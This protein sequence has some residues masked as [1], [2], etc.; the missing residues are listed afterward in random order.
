VSTT[1]QDSQAPLVSPATVA[2]WRRR[3]E[4]C[5]EVLPPPEDGEQPANGF[6]VSG[7]A[8]AISS[9]GEGK[10]ANGF[11]LSVDPGAISSGGEG[12]RA[13]GFQAK[14]HVAT[15]GSTDSVAHSFAESQQAALNAMIGFAHLEAPAQPL[16]AVKPGAALAQHLA[17]PQGRAAIAA[18]TQPSLVIG[19]PPVT[20]QPGLPVRSVPVLPGR[21]PATGTQARRERSAIWDHSFAKIRWLPLTVILVIQAALSLRLVWSNSAFTDEALY[22]WSGRVEWAH[23]LHGGFI[24]NFPTYFSGAPVIYPPV[25][26]MAAALGGLTGARILSLCFM[27]NA[28]VLLHGVTRRIFDRRSAN[29][30]AAVFAGLGATQ[31][32]G[33]FATYDAMAL[34][35]L[36]LAT[37]LCV[38]AS[39]SHLAVQVLLLFGAG[40][41][42]ALAD[43]AKY[44]AALF[45]PVV[46]AVAG[47]V[48]WRT[49]GRKHGIVTVLVLL[50]VLGLVLFLGIREGGQPYWRGITSSTL[51]RTHGVSSPLGILADS[52]G[53]VFL[54]VVL[55]LIGAG[56]AMV[57]QTQ[58]PAKLC[59]LVLAGAVAL[60]PANQARIHVFTSLFKHVGFGAWFAAAVAGYALASLADAV[61]AVKKHKALTVSTCAAAVGILVGALLAQTH[62]ASWPNT[63]SLVAQLRTI[64]PDHRGNVLSS[65]NGNVIEYYLEDELDGMPFYGT[66]FFHYQDPSTGQSLT[67][68]PAYADAIRHRYFSV[69]VLSFSDTQATDEAIERDISTYGGYTLV[70]TLPY[71]VSGSASVF[72]IWVREDSG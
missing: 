5:S 60:A 16:P 40:G 50:W 38:R 8:D 18:P 71:R 17:P 3:Q 41:A 54:A 34:M 13:N 23:W 31:F 19:Q 26:A 15:N 33:A 29:F 1:G 68:R 46:I 11:Q 35:L 6:Q 58:L 10:R 21:P 44:A 30:A 72:R 28:T 52:F 48:A 49:K 47:F 20:V 61:P 66:S 65:D 67:N 43:A 25:G 24:P 12:K 32:L 63:T 4:T 7:D 56:V 45:D 57:R 55:G 51:T 9:G 64:L 42:L 27:L 36:A 62:F 37:W 69:I 39:E 70:A 2:E 14:D 22:L 59:A 53:W